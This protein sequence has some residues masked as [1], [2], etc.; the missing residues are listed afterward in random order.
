MS[1]SLSPEQQTVFNAYLAG[2]NVFITGPGGTGKTHLIR[3]IYNNALKQK[4][5]V[6]VCALTG[7]AALLLACNAKTVHS[8]AKIGLGKGL[9]VDILS[10]ILKYRKTKP[11]VSTKLLI[12][13][14][15]SMMSMRLFELLD[16]LGRKIRKTELPFGGI[17][18]IFSGDFYQLPPVPDKGDEASAKFCFESPRWQE[19]FHKQIELRRNFRQGD[20]TLASVLNQIRT[21]MLDRDGLELLRCRVGLSLPSDSLVVPTKLFPRKY[22]V[23]LVNNS[24]MQKID[25]EEYIY[26]PELVTDEVTPNVS[27]TAIEEEAAHMQNHA[28]FDELVCLKKGAQVMCIANIDLEDAKICNGSV[29]IVTGFT[30]APDGNEYPI[31]KFQNGAERT[32]V[33]HSWPSENIKGLCITQVPLILAWAIT[34]HKAQGATLDL[35]ELDIGSDVFEY[36]QTYVGLSR[37]R[38]LDGLYISEFMPEKIKANPK[39]HTFYETMNVLAGLESLT[40]V[41]YP[42]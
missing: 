39:V 20:S 13:D 35:L 3:A 42:I 33:R 24:E 41:K 28:L 19:T 10:K 7:C 23:E 30:T 37:V 18:V 8:W 25:T 22:S 16:Y 14:E 9:D 1:L 29:G 11:W 17:Q 40:T 15:V 36:G 32:M 34:I 27:E 31:V 6:Q 2:Q 4:K 21:G 5:P 38:S 12:I 26:E